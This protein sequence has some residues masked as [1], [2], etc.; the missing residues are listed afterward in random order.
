MRITTIL[1]LKK[2]LII[3]VLTVTLKAD[4][5]PTMESFNAGELSPLLHLRSKFSKYDN[6]CALLQNMLPLSQGPVFRRPGMRFIAQTQT[7]TELSRLVKFEFN[8]TDAYILEFGD[9]YMRVYRDGGQ[10][11]VLTGTSTVPTS[12]VAQWKLDD[13]AASTVVLDAVGSPTHNGV[14]TTNT[15]NLSVAGQVDEAFN[16]QGIYAVD[17]A[18][19]DDF[20]FDDS[21]G[22]GFSIAAWIYIEASDHTQVILSKWNEQIPAREWLLQ[23]SSN[24]TLSLFLY[25]ED[26]NSIALSTALQPLSDGWYNIV[27]TYDGRGGNAAQNGIKIYIDKTIVVEDIGRG[28]GANYVQMRN[29]QASVTIDTYINSSGNEDFFWENKL[30]NISVFNAELTVAQISDMISSTS[31]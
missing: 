23:L 22:E 1:Y 10:I 8:K 15:S 20:T 3:L 19:H 16:M 5:R 6:G 2:L 29:T 21:A 27:V 26:N 9:L 24:E 18:D 17:I 4:I 11:I 25:D 31:F 14:S 7:M 30:D 12:A 13:N 28:S